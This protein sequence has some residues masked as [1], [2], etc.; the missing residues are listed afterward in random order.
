M[1]CI[2]ELCLVDDIVIVLGTEERGYT[3]FGVKCGW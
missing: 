3:T 1:K 2:G